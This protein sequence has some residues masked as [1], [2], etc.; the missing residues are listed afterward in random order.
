MVMGVNQ[1][2]LVYNLLN[3]GVTLIHGTYI[4]GELEEKLTT[5]L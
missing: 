3:L 5:L 2:P 4:A 1:A